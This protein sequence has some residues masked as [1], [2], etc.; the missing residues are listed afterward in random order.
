M[1]K[2]PKIL[3]TVIATVV[4][5]VLVAVAALA[6]AVYDG[7]DRTLPSVREADMGLNAFVH[8]EAVKALDGAAEKDDISL[9]LNEYAM[10]ELLYAVA[11]QVKIPMV[12]TRGAYATYGEDGALSLELP[13]RAA[14]ILPT[15]VTGTLKA[16]YTDSVLTL[17]VERASLGKFPC[18][19]GIVR[20]LVLNG[21]NQKRFQ[22]ALTDAGIYGTL[23]LQS[24]SF[25]MTSAE[26]ADT[27][28]AQTKDDPN[29]LLYELLCDLCLNSPDL[30][31][32]SF[33][34]N[35][36]YGVV[37]HADRLAY[38]PE[39]DGELS[40]PLDLASAAESTRALYENGLTREN[41][42]P[43]FH[44]YASGYRALNETEKA[45]VDALGLGEN[46]MGVRTVSA[47][48]MAEVL[49]DQSA[50]LAA[51]I[52]NR[53]VTLTVTER[54]MNTIF[55]GLNVIG[56]GVAF[57]SDRKVAYLSL[58]AVDIALG[59]RE[60]RVSVV[61]NVNGK[62]LCGHVSTVCPDSDRMALDAQIT[63][64]R[65]GE[66]A[67]NAGRTALFLRYLDGVLDSQVWVSADAQTSTLTLDLGAALEEL[68]DFAVLLRLSSATDM[69]C[70]R[71]GSQ[72]QLQLLFRLF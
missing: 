25:F 59:D 37:L 65:L 30:L 71:I 68:S 50:G 14:G 39:T 64:L 8:R 44:Y 28:A 17:T 55:A 69:Q 58:E 72:G 7:S 38:H 5:L 33:G 41:V 35:R 26:I 32:F 52:L 10:N 27:V 9:L 36:L 12:E 70:R 19:S 54:Q 22:A 31:E 3:L 62:R 47:L 45:A 49:T 29:A 40:Y 46:G 11:S 18:T 61:L 21:G 1:K 23:D 67:M 42:S 24:L 63:E 13:V 57:C 66:K 53:A 51:S 2:I 15:R 34:E 43:V 48:T 60:L 6:I 56:S 16:T 20:A 4:V